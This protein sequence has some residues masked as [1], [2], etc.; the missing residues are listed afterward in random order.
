MGKKN[1]SPGSIKFDSKEEEYF[2]WYLQE[3]VNEGYIHKIDVNPQSFDLSDPVKVKIQVHKQQKNKTKVIDKDA[4]LVSGKIYTPDFEII[5]TPK[6]IGV[7][8]G[9]EKDLLEKRVPF[10]ANSKLY[11]CIEIK[12]AYNMHNMTRHFE[13]NQAW[14]YNKWGVFVQKIVPQLLFQSTFTP[15]RYLRSDGDTKWRKMKWNPTTLSTYLTK[16]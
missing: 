8:I 4:T 7:V 6:A 15:Q 16:K 10:F 14:V 2:H 9:S 11:S 3:L 1:S 5:W 13:T 12:P